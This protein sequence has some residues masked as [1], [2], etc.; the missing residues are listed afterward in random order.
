MLPALEPIPGS[1]GSTP[2]LERLAFAASADGP[3]PAQDA[4]WHERAFTAWLLCPMER[5]C[6]ELCS[7]VAA[8]IGR[9]GDWLEIEAYGRLVPRSAT[10][11]EGR[12]FLCDIE[13]MLA[14]IRHEWATDDHGRSRSGIERVLDI[15]QTEPLLSLKTLSQRLGMSAGRLGSAFKARTGLHFRRYLQIVRIRNA[16]YRLVD[17]LRPIKEAAA[18]AGYTDPSKLIRDFRDLLGTTP[19]EFQK[20]LAHRFARSAAR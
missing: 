5:K 8:N 9:E 16:V 4:E 10:E 12:F 20:I 1:L 14:V 13:A 18:L 17:P 3:H 2:L 6:A 19:G 15:M 7:F 11:A